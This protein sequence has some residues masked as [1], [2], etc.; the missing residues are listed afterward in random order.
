VNDFLLSVD[1]TID[2]LM[3]IAR[4]R[5][6]AMVAVLPICVELDFV[7]GEPVWYLDGDKVTEQQVRTAWKAA[8]VARAAHPAYEQR[9]RVAR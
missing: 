5:G 7:Q 4:A 9:E 1:A 6:T 3:D 2:T 8:R